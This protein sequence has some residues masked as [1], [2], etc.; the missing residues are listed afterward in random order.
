MQLTEGFKV[1]VL[2]SGEGQDEYICLPSGSS[3]AKI[4]GSS[5]DEQ[6][7][8]TICQEAAPLKKLLYYNGLLI[9]FIF[10]MGIIFGFQRACYLFFKA[11]LELGVWTKVGHLY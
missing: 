8:I 5:V 9:L 3:W 1:E 7:S 6:K 11:Y 2:T 10:P 4:A